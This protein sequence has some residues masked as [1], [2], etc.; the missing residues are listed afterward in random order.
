MEPH[1]LL[2]DFI[3]RDS[4]NIFKP[5]WP[6]L[7]NVAA[8]WVRECVGG[9]VDEVHVAVLSFNHCKCRQIV[10]GLGAIYNRM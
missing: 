6:M 1:W 7:G 2:S 8:C 9:P 5:P 10:A 3:S 4:I